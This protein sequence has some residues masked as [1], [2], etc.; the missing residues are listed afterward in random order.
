MGKK[1]GLSKQSEPGLFDSELQEIAGGSPPVSSSV[2][3]AAIDR[4]L[5]TAIKCPKNPTGDAVAQGTSQSDGGGGK[6]SVQ[7]LSRTAKPKTKTKITGVAFGEVKGRTLIEVAPQDIEFDKVLLDKLL[8]FSGLFDVSLGILKTEGATLLT[9]LLRVHV[10]ERGHKLFCIAGYFALNV[11]KTLPDAPKTILVE[12]HD[13]RH[14]SDCQNLAD[15]IERWSIVEFQCIAL[16]FRLR[17]QEDRKQKDRISC[18]DAIPA[19]A[20]QSPESTRAGRDMEFFRQ[21]LLTCD[22]EVGE[23]LIKKPQT[24]KQKADTFRVSPRTIT[25]WARNTK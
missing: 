21:F 11:I 20:G 15:V 18:S 9:D 16:L 13:I 4:E 12:L 7:K 25:T 19:S 14:E 8:R 23:Q 6:R 17:K 24:D 5:P 10:V 3:T 1:P 22:S 2:A